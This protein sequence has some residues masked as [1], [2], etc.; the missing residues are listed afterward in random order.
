VILKPFWKTWCDFKDKT[1]EKVG[2]SRIV[3]K[4]TLLP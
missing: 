4:G 3:I 2:K 1:P